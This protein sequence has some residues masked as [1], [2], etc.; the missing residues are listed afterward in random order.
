MDSGKHTLWIL[1]SIS[2]A[3]ILIIIAIISL[4]PLHSPQKDMSITVPERQVK[5]N[6]TPGNN[7]TTGILSEL[8]DECENIRGN[9]LIV[10]R[11][12]IDLVNK[13]FL[14][15][16]YTKTDPDVVRTIEEKSVN[17]WTIEIIYD[18]EFVDRMN[19]VSSE[20]HNNPG[21]KVSGIQWSI[22]GCQNPPVYEALIYVSEYTPEN[23]RLN[24]TVIDGWKFSVYRAASYPP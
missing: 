15:Y 23:Q 24:G 8:E 2:M 18:T 11:W 17:N 16:T 10:S 14:V 21:M 12:E 13:T 20:I 7:L 3:I 5:E 19:N 6:Q 22:D 1:F 9:N 4:P